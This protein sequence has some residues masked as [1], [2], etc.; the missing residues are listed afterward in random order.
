MVKKGNK[1]IQKTTKV[2]LRKKREKV[3]GN[4]KD[5][6]RFKMSD[7]WRVWE[8]EWIWPCL[9]GTF[10]RTDK[11]PDLTKNLITKFEKDDASILKCKMKC[12]MKAVLKNKMNKSTIKTVKRRVK[13]ECKDWR[14]FF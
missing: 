4:R 9:V 3:W 12:N 1:T 13:E 5:N 2:K 11:N 7:L 6:S 14:I 8:E 10:Q